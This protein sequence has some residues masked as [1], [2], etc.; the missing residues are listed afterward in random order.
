VATE[1]NNGDIAELILAAAI[2][3]KFKKRLSAAK[4][5]REQI[6]SIGDLPRITSGD[7]KGTLRTIISNSFRSQFNV[8]DRDIVS[9]RISRVTDNISVVVK[10]PANS[11]R[12]MSAQ[13]IGSRFSNFEN[14]FNSA[15]N[16]V[17][18]DT[19]IKRKVFNTQFNLKKDLI[20]IQGIG[21]K[22]QTETKVDVRVDITTAGVK[23][24]RAS[25]QI[26]LKFNT[27][28]FA[29]TVGLEFEKFADIFEEL[30]I[31]DYTKDKEEFDKAVFGVY[32]EILGKRFNSRKEVTQ[33]NEV[34]AL[35]EAARK[36][37]T[38]RIKRELDNKIN[39][40]NFKST[41]A[42]FIKK[43]ATLNESGVELV[44]F[45]DNGRFVKQTFGDDF[46][47]AIN[48]MDLAAT[49]KT[50]SRNVKGA[51]IGDETDNPTI[52]IYKKGGDP[53]RDLLIEFRYRSDSLQPKGQNYY[54][55]KM[56]TLV[57][58]GESLYT[59]G[60]TNE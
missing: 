32:P 33:S 57:L 5:S 13:P 41:L 47:N 50:Y 10:I 22:G 58:A 1:F 6:I 14:I 38:G 44:E 19:E 45:L 48:S 25:S 12:Y 16:F 30:G 42:S 26:S 49:I 11:E 27:G 4:L 28:Q 51:R 39:D 46:T 37:F 54:L 21:T 7:V 2:A 35:K 9:K 36:V 56:R 15:T 18:A 43:K 60:A 17:N 24:S 8:S 34:R 23:M 31:T 3:A 20:E 40:V 55:I 52:C 53:L 59:L 29:Q